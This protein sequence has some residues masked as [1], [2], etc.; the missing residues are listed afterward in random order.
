MIKRLVKLVGF[1]P[2]L[3]VTFP[4]EFCFYTMRWAITGEAFPSS[5]IIEKF[6]AW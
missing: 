4:L 2:V 1:I 5:P 3:L 6:I